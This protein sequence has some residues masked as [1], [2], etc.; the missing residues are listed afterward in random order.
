[1]TLEIPG[2]KTQDPEEY[3]PLT[4]QEQDALQD[5]PAWR[6]QWTKDMTEG[7]AQPPTDVTLTEEELKKLLPTRR[8]RR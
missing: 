2:Q 6:E 4:P 8:R 1:M 3:K 5:N 7:V